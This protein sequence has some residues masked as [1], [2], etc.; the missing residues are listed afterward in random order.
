MV[1]SVIGSL[2]VQVTING[3]GGSR[4]SKTPRGYLRSLE[5]DD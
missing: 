4:K 3:C 5:S 2:Q 1:L